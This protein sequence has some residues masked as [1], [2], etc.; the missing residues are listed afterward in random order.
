MLWDR[1]GEEGMDGPWSCSDSV[2]LEGALP[3]SL[4]LAQ[5]HSGE[6][7]RENAMRECGVRKGT[8]EGGSGR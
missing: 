6:V 3:A 7:C 4:Q 8:E 2:L 5:V 1:D